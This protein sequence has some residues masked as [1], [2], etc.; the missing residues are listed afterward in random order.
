MLAFDGKNAT[1]PAVN[2]VRG[3]SIPTVTGDVT[4]VMFLS[5]LAALLLNGSARCNAPTVSGARCRLNIPLERFSPMDTLNP[6]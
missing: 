2:T 4:Y 3:R 1:S 5:N 6:I